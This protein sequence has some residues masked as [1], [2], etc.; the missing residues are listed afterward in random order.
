MAP[1]LLL[2][3]PPPLLALPSTSRRWLGAA[4]CELAQGLIVPLS[5]ADL[6]RKTLNRG[7][8]NAEIHLALKRPEGPFC[9]KCG[10]RLKVNLLEG[11]WAG[12]PCCRV[13]YAVGDDETVYSRFEPNGVPSCRHYD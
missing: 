12:C 10:T 1:H 3:L 8:S 6:H 4:T 7:L 13:E 2:R 11:S 5:I 9:P